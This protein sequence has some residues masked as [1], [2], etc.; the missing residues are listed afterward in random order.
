MHG[1]VEKFI[2]N[3]S[4]ESWMEEPLGRPGRRW[5]ENIKI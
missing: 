5:K 4:R 1:G 3:C 2:Q